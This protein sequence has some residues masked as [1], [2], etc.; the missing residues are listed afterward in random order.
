MGSD[1][2]PRD[3]AHAP[4]LDA[5]TGLRW[6]AAFGVFGF[7]MVIFAP[8]APVVNSFLAIGDYGVA[9]FFVL[10]GFVLTYSYRPTT[11]KSTFY[12][13]RFARIYPLHFVTL[14]LAIPVF[15]SFMPDP[16]DWWVKPV[17]VGILLLSIFLLQGWSRD[18]AILFSGNPAAWTLTVE[19]F[20]YT[21]HP[22]LSRGLTRLGRRG[23]LI[24]AAVVA[25][26]T[27]DFRIAI[28]FDPS[29]FV[30]GLPLPILRV[31][32]FLLG[33][34]LAWAFRLGWRMGMHPW[35]PAAGIAVV[36][37]SFVVAEQLAPESGVMTVIM[38]LLP[39]AMTLL[40][41][42]L[43]V[44]TSAA[45]VAG[46]VRWMRWRPL[47]ALGEWSFAFYLIHATIIYAA[48]TVVGYQ[49][50][51]WMNLLWYAALLVVAIAGAAALHLWLERP[52]ESK[53]RAA[54]VRWRSRRA[55]RRTETAPS[56][57]A[58]SSDAPHG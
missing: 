45:E 27:I 26:I 4:R 15:Y 55:A 9:F 42:A 21:L 58:T 49:P 3:A 8:L 46:R 31:N 16:A 30:A 5:I 51:R 12:W 24:A 22:I 57:A 13:R 6:W 39:A 40:F 14:L 17:N 52:V 32:E 1:V 56:A 54:E 20:F 10:S 33:M 53:M 34:C 35:L 37:T 48:L 11:A 28:Q 18:P 25:I 23:A 43:I 41:G 19:A 47:V 2:T 44:T 36:A 29:G 7:H 50:A 38:M